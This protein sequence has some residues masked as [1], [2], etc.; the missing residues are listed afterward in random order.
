[1]VVPQHHGNVVVLVVRF[2]DSTD[3]D[4]SALEFPSCLK[5]LMKVLGVVDLVVKGH[6]EFGVGH[7][8]FFPV[9]DDTAGPKS[10][11]SYSQN[12]SRSIPFS[13]LKTG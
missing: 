3:P 8:G 12:L 13:T 2:D 1:M 7:D 10:T 5:E 9:V 6:L 11:F 4:A